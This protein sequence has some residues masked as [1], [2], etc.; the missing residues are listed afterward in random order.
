M[1]ILFEI[2]H[3]MPETNAESGICPLDHHSALFF[4][5]SGI[6]VSGSVVTAGFGA[7]LDGWS[8]YLSSEKFWLVYSLTQKRN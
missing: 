4:I 8:S 2:S 1:M 7:D 5:Q 3:C 6:E